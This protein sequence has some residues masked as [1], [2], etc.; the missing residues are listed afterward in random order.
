MNSERRSNELDPY[1]DQFDLFSFA[2]K[3]GITN[4]DVLAKLFTVVKKLKAGEYKSFSD[5][6]KRWVMKIC[7]FL[8]LDFKEEKKV[9]IKFSKIY[10]ISSYLKK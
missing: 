4:E 7:D 3:H 5:F 8:L 1:R 2:D 6:K 9:L 10:G